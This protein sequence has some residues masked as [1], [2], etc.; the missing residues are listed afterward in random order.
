MKA[1][2][3]LFAASML[4]THSL[5]DIQLSSP[6]TQ[7]SLIQGKTNASHTII[8]KERTLAVTPDGTFVFGVGRDAEA[9]QTIQEIDA[10]G[11]AT[12]YTFQVIQRTYEVQPIDGIAKEK[13]T[14]P[15]SVLSRIKQ[16]TALVKKARKT[17]SRLEYFKMPFITPTQG[18]VT[19]VYG[20]QRIYNGIPKRP[21]YGI[22]IAAPKGTIVQ[23]PADGVVTL[24]HDD[25]YFSG[26]TLLI[27][28]GYGISSTFIH[29][30]SILVKEGD[31]VKQGESI[32]RVGSTG[33]STGPHLDW[34]INWYGVRLD[35]QLVLQSPIQ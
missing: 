29:L 4:S 19:G 11:K 14:P 2:A 1:Q 28:H 26:G 20:S 13:V 5:A 7:G 32:A 33:R 3:F 16:E 27:D 6:I 18:R 22:D 8:F 34:R 9:L 23:A 30:D 17:D 10:N 25:M 15:E 21:H 31:K 35:P 24:T 12:T